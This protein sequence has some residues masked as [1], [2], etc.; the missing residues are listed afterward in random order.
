MSVAVKAYYENGEVKLTE[1]A[2][3]N[4]I[5][6]GS[7]AGKIQVPDNFDEELDELKEYMG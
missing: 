5:K 1:P 6:F 2:P 7:L 4:E 3:K